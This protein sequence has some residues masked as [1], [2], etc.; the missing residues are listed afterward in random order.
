MLCLSDTVYVDYAGAGQY[1]P[2]QLERHVADLT[3]HVY[4]NA[5]S[6]G[7]HGSMTSLEVEQARD[8]VLR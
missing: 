4:G 7:H 5:H 1:A 8:M 2:E 6:A 3:S